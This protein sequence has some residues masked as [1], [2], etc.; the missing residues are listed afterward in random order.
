VELYPPPLRE[1]KGMAAAAAVS[2]EAPTYERTITLKQDGHP[3]GITFRAKMSPE[4]Q[5]Q[6]GA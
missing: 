4:K 1:R 6:I 5:K 2:V 3:L